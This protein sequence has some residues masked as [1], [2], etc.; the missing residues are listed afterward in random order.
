MM[1]YPRVCIAVSPFNNDRVCFC[2]FKLKTRLL[3]TV[4]DISTFL[5]TR[6]DV[7]AFSP[8]EGTSGD[9]CFAYS[10]WATTILY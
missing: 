9:L 2:V 8:L 6:N 7:M 10:E 3:R 1:S 4:T 5:L